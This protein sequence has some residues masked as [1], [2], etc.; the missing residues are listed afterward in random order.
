MTSAGAPDFVVD[1]PAWEQFCELVARGG[2]VS[3]H[4][5]RPGDQS[6]PSATFARLEIRRV[7]HHR[8]TVIPFLMEHCGLAGQTVLEFG[9]GT[10]GLSVAMVQAGVARV[11][12]V[13]PVELNCETGRWRTR[14]YGLDGA[15]HFHH[16]LNTRHLQF[17]DGQFDAVVCS[18]VLQYVPD[19]GE[20]NILLTEMA[21]LTRPGGL[22]IVCGSG[23]SFYPAGPHSSKWWSNLM[24]SR[25][26]RF[27]YN[28][29]ISYWELNRTLRPLG[30]STFSQGSKAVQRWRN[31]SLAHRKVVYR[32]A[33]SAIIG[34]FRPVAMLLRLSTGAP[35]EAFLPYLDLAFR[36]GE[37]PRGSDSSDENVSRRAPCPSCEKRLDR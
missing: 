34:G 12:A 27:G 7:E 15:I 22:L 32:L 19:A 24:P 35:L 9:A 5:S 21:R 10:G 18:S 20:R 13:E 8:R 23:N 1:L 26:A 30:F 28:R 36:K 33:I 31:R 6:P 25:A 3:D 11:H 2:G 16:V 17:A 14:A 4:P 29:G 37:S